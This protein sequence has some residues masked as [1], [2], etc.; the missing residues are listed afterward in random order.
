MTKLDNVIIEQGFKKNWLAR[1]MNLSPADFS[2]KKAG[3]RG[4][5]FT[6]VEREQLAA[7]LGVAVSELFPELA[8][9]ERA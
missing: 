1:Q 3:W 2:Q 5:R 4:R 6:P 7:L 9:V 8:E